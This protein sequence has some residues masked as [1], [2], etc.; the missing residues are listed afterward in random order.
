MIKVEKNFVFRSL[1]ACNELTCFIHKTL[2]PYHLKQQTI[3]DYTFNFRL[4]MTV[5]KRRL[6]RNC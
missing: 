5:S 3:P 6:H 4:F 2:F 1:P